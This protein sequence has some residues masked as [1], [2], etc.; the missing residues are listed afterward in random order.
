MHDKSAL[1][2]GVAH[3]LHKKDAVRI[4]QSAGL[5]RYQHHQNKLSY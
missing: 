4:E 5:G 1:I 2:E 3:I